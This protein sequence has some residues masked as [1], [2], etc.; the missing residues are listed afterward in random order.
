LEGADET[1]QEEADTDTDLEETDETDPEET[2]ETDPE[3]DP[4]NEPEEADE[5]TDSTDVNLTINHD[6]LIVD[7]ADAPAPARRGRRSNAGK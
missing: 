3:E 6:E 5:S 2:D 7:P 4:E 1:E